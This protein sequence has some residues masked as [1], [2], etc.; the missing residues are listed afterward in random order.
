MQ[1]SQIADLLPQNSLLVYNNTKVIHARLYFRRQTGALIE[2][3]LLHP[4]QPKEVQLA[5]QADRKLYLG[6]YDRK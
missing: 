3:L 2:I 5:M 6:M 1:F 4:H